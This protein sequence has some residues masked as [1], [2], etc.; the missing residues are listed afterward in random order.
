M[1][2]S[3][4]SSRNFNNY[5]FDPAITQTN[6]IVEYIWLDGSLKNLR[7]KTRVYADKVIT[8]LE[9]LEWWTYDGSSTEQA[10]TNDSEIWIK[11]VALF[12]DPFRKNGCWLALC[13]EYK[14]DKKHLL[15]VISDKS[16]ARLWMTLKI[17]K[18]GLEQNKNISYM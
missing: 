14:G 10:I 7:G 11:P 18:L 17:M 8:C 9:D 13:E 3:T 1:V 6:F 16:A 2:D 5:T 15:L 4:A 12:K